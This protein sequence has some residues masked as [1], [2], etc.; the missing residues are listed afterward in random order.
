MHQDAWKDILENIKNNFEI[1]ELDRYTVDKDGGIEVEYVIFHG[2][3][4]LMK[5]E[6]IAKPVIIDKKVHYSNRIGAD[7]HVEYLYDPNQKSYKLLAYKWQEDNED[8][9]EMEAGNLTKSF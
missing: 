6:Y 9:L 4:G 1:E 7:S 3:L 2:P 8:W 5:L